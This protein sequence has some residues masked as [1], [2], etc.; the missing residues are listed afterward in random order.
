MTH[1]LL[2]LAWWR[3]RPRGFDVLLALALFV[4]ALATSHV[5]LQA[6]EATEPGFAMPGRA[7]LVLGLAA[8]TL[9]LA[10]RR[11]FPLVA[12]VISCAG[13]LFA[14]IVADSVEATVTAVALAIAV[15]SAAAYSPHPLRHV[16]CGG[17]V[18]AIMVRLWVEVSG[19]IAPVVP[20]QWA[21]R[22]MALVA[23]LW[24]L[25]AMWALGAA[26]RRGTVRADE[27]R[28]QTAALA[29]EREERARS[30]VFEERVRIARE[31]HDVVA[32][33]VSVMG[34]QAG[35]AR[36]TMAADP[37]RASDNLAAIEA[38]SRDAVNELHRLLGFL[39][40]D[41][42]S[43]Q[44]VPRPDVAAIRALASN[45]THNLDVAIRVEGRERPLPQ[46]L[47]LSAYRIV[48]EALTNVVKHAS[49]SRVEVALRFLPRS[50]SIDVIDDG[51]GGGDGPLTAGLGLLGMRERVGL[52]GGTIDAGPRSGGG[53]AVHVTLPT[54]GAEP[55]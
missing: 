9:P 39:R 31:L 35:A 16:A 47:A 28:R 1:R 19:P 50:L 41:G 2:V 23:N 15:Y 6:L 40:R 51:T 48:Q 53:F 34:V 8:T 26:I 30:A 22:V 21:L 29:A 33:H 32:H 14:R 54:D 52:H 44:R 45:V 38:S 12:L 55:A 37:A 24:L 36:L 27:L 49:A 3:Q 43:D 25:L 11:R 17:A 13:F 4:A 7:A 20:N 46:T 42:E 5:S 18:A 10:F